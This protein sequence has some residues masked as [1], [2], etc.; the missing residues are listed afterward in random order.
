MRRREM[1]VLVLDEMQELDQE[2]APSLGIAEQRAD[3]HLRRRLDL[4]AF[5]DRPPPP[6]ARARMTRLPLQG[7]SFRHGHSNCWLAPMICRRSYRDN[8]ALSSHNRTNLSTGR[9]RGSFA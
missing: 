2:I 7:L 6:L 5:G 4:A 9:S 8:K 1:A 3:L